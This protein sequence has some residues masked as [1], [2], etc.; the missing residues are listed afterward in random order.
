MKFRG[1]IIFIFVIV[2]FIAGAYFKDNVLKLYNFANIQ[3][4]R[5]VVEI[6]ETNFGA[7]INEASKEILTPPP[8][9]ISGRLKEHT[10]QVELLQSKVISETNIQRQ[11]NG[12]LSALTEN[13]KL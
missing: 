10:E 4:S 6:Q 3:I 2:V 8:L 1:L 5:K 12:N 13:V 7:V 9:N 11:E